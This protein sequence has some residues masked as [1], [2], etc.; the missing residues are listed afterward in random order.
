MGNMITRNKIKPE[1][2]SPAGDMEKFDFALAYGADAVYLGGESFGLRAKSTNFTLPE[3]KESV[4]KAEAVGAKVYVTVN[5]FAHQEDINQLPEYL[6]AL[7]AIKPHGLIISDLG[8]F[9]LARKYAPDIPI[10]ISTQ[11]NSTNSAAVN[12]WHNLGASRVV[13]AR[14]LSLDE[15]RDVARHTDCDLEVFAHG[16]MCMSYSGRCL[17]SNYLTGRDSNRGACTH[18]CRWSY[19]LVESSRPGEYLPVEEDGRGSYIMN[20]KD[21]NLLRY[22]PALTDAGVRSLKIEG[23]VKSCYYVSVVTKVYRE[24]I[25]TVFF[26]RERF[27][28]RLPGWEEEL[29]TVSHRQ[30]TAGFLEGRPKAEGHRYESSGYI[31]NYDFIGIVK[32]YDSK[33]KNLIIEQR[34]NFK[35]GDRIEFLTPAAG[36]E[37]IPM[38]LGDFYD[39]AG[40]LLT[41]AAHPQMTIYLPYG[42]SLPEYTILRRK[43]E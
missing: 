9:A 29:A 36:S 40:D 43:Y 21:L 11:A 13:L 42:R 14:E 30:Y 35:R 28:E 18:P 5:I 10:H 7:A 27:K 25:D 33:G 39:E 2:L 12:Q 19:S 8:V 4:K 23:R 26:E 41:A 3:I 20:S 17:L 31:R 15:I 6:E 1:I 24:A 38:V 22:L 37:S 34:N 16:A 32:G